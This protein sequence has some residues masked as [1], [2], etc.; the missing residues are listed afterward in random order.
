MNS[1]NSKELVPAEAFLVN[2]TKELK[3]LFMNFHL[4][5]ILPPGVCN[6]DDLGNP[7][8]AVY[9]G[10]TRARVSSQAWKKVI[11]DKMHEL[12]K[13]TTYRTATIPQR[14]YTDLITA[15]MSPAAA[16]TKVGETFSDG[17]TPGK[18]LVD[19]AKILKAGVVSA[20][21]STNVSIFLS[22][23]EY[24]GILASCTGGASMDVGEILKSGKTR[25]GGII[26]LFGRMMADL[27]SMN[28]EAASSFAHAITTHEAE[29]ESD[30]FTLC[31]DKATTTG[32]GHLG[33]TSFTSGV[34]YRNIVLDIGTLCSNMVG[35]SEDDIKEL[36]AFFVTACLEA[37]PE[38]KKNSMYCRTIPTYALVDLTN[39]PISL[40]GA[41]EA[42]VCAE[43][44][45]YMESSIK[46]LEEHRG[47][48]QAQGYLVKES[49]G[50]RVFTHKELAEFVY[51]H[52]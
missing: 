21:L 52:V 30:Y 4:L 43:G 37:F 7:K 9:G 19:G 39:L 26:S 33:Q 17:K 1:I 24:Q 34:Y 14:L 46:A 47:K 27:P 20:P 45:G 29:F 50:G 8:S 13:K 23:E 42:P 15:G 5:Q 36:A 32:A 38:G 11:R 49:C 3:N 25:F 22:E 31:D 10:A 40:A 48:M 2:N 6:R 16:L 51:K 44:T 12:S 28:V 18:L 41:F 35:F